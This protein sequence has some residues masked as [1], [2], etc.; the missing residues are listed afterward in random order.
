MPYTCIVNMTETKK[1]LTMNYEKIA[2]ENAAPF[3]F[4]AA[5]IEKWNHGGY[6][7]AKKIVEEE[8]S[9]KVFCENEGEGIMNGTNFTLISI[10]NRSYLGFNKIIAG[11]VILK[12]GEKEKVRCLTAE[13]TQQIITTL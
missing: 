4:E 6:N 9:Q 2:F 1:L 10:R 7:P 12:Q 3:V 5:G 11:I 8:F 13:Q